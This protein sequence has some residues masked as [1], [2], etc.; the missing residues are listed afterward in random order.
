MAKVFLSHSSS[1]KNLV[2]SIA[3]QI[4]R[5]KCVLDEW[6]FDPG[7][8]VLDEIIK[9]LEASDLLVLFISDKA[10][11][12][13]WVKKEVVQAR[14]NI[15]KGLLEKILPI[16]IDPSISYTDSRIPKW[17]SRSYNLKKITNERVL[18]NR[19]Q[20]AMRSINLINTGE[21]NVA[22]AIFVGRNKE[23]QAFEQDINNID[24]WIPTCIVANSY[25]EGMGRRT[26]LR[27][28]LERNNIVDKLIYRPLTISIDSRESIENFI[29]QLNY[30]NPDTNITKVDLTKMTLDEK[31]DLAFDIIKEYIAA[32]EIV[33]IID[34]GGIVK[35]DGKFVDWFIALI[36]KVQVYKTTIFC[37][38]STFRPKYYKNEKDDKWFLAYDIPELNKTDTKTLFLRLLKAYGIQMDRIEDKEFFLKNLKGIPQQILYAVS[39]I[40]TDIFMAKNNISEIVEF[41]DRY[42]STMLNIIK[43]DFVAYQIAVFLASQDIVNL[44]LVFK[45]FGDGEDV[46]L[47]ISRLYDISAFTFVF[48]DQSHI[49]LNST[50]AD[51]ISRI[52]ETL[53]DK[54][55][56]AFI[57]ARKELLSQDLDSL[58]CYDYSS[59]LITIQEMMKNGSKIPTKYYMPSLLIKYVAKLYEAGRYNKVIEVCENLLLNTNYDSQILRETEYLL[60]QSYARTEN[61]QFFNYIDDFKDDPVSYHFLKGFYFRFKKDND[62]ALKEFS[63]VLDISP[64]HSRT[65]REVVSI[66]L[67]EGKYKEALP[68]AKDNYYQRRNNIFHLQSYFIALSHRDNIDEFELLE[69]EKLMNEAKNLSDS[70][71]KAKDI[72]TCMKGEYE[73]YIQKNFGSAETT[74][75]EALS[76]NENKQYPYRSLRE[77]YKLEKKFDLMI[78]LEEKYGHEFTED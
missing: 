42:S 27:V 4:G 5:Q 76:A 77:I 14:K 57:K 22:N 3:Q 46:R 2:R 70:Y 75:Q 49:K 18:L 47:A 26:F 58:V 66:Y 55:R 16:I 53:V 43:K 51:Y 39:L 9:K 60:L 48:D 38:V 19:I 63:Q 40:K 8:R 71:K 30:I 7:E 6:S 10:L 67:S 74:L 21:T 24:D 33:F 56:N 34:N 45:V 73:Y 69:I 17:M 15:D 13:P 20:R 37:L 65:K 12:S 11:D 25:Y 32:N 59:F 31:I 54:Y 36:E 72:Y 44:E 68:A 28:A 41:S 61:Q 64:N 62:L 29:Y 78:K 35:P 1:D 50:L 23:L 52:R